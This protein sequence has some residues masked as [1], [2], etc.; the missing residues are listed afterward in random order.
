MSALP[1]TCHL[2]R[3]AKNVKGKHHSNQ[4]WQDQ[5]EGQGSS[6]VCLCSRLHDMMSV[7]LTHR[8]RFLAILMTV[9]GEL[10]PIKHAT[11]AAAHVAS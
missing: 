1:S 2:D 9:A 6:L 7:T 10:L 3:R 4:A 11:L 5:H 8:K